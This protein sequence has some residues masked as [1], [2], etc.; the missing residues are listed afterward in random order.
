MK[1][2]EEELAILQDFEAG[3][4]VPAI[5]DQE[6]LQPFIEAAKAYGKKTKPVRIRLSE[7]DFHDLQVLAMQ[8]GVPYQ[9]LIRSILH[10][11]VRSIAKNPK[12][13]NIPEKAAQ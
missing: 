1:F 6:T 11:Y 10:T 4:L 13:K 12:K 7:Q 8:K 2:T 3:T 9:T 5:T